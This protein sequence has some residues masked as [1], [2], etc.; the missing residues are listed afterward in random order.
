VSWTAGVSVPDT[1]LVIAEAIG[2][3]IAK[4]EDRSGRVWQLYMCGLAVLK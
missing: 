3:V 2:R 4:S 1:R